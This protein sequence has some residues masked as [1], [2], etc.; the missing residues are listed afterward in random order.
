MTTVTFTG[1]TVEYGPT[2]DVISVGQTQVSLILPS[3]TSTFT[4]SIVDASDSVPVVEIDDDLLQVVIDGVLADVLEDSA[5][6]QIDLELGTVTSAAGTSTFLGLSIEFGQNTVDRYF[7]IDGVNLPNITSVAEWNAFDDSITNVGPA[8]GA[9]APGVAIPWATFNTATVTEDDEF[10]GRPGDEIFRGGIGDDYFNSSDGA[11]TYFGGTG[12]DQVNFRGDPNGV[13]ANL[14]TGKAIDGWGKTDTLNS[15]EMLR[16]SMFDDTLIGN[17]GGNGIRGLAGDDFLNGGKGIDAVRYDRDER[18]GG[19]AGVTVNLKNGT[20]T[21]GFGD[22][23][24]LRNF[25]NVMGTEVKDTLIGSGGKNTLVGLGGNDRLVGLNGRDDLQGGDGRDVL[26]GGAGNDMLTG[27]RQADRFVFKGAFG[28]DTIT[29]FT[30]AGKLEKIDLSA[31]A[32]IKGFR[33]LKKSHL[34]NVNGDAVIDD[35][36]G[37]TIT[38]DGVLKGALLANDFIF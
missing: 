31:I 22:T 26:D 5:T 11:D 24:T 6:S 17:G 18:Y 1:I 9:F 34:S 19:T 38:I 32:S 13:T 35:G 33:D 25:E 8:T 29:D 15:I 16:G 28:D 36:A 3:A 23:D 7:I 12:I 2:D 10:Y 20:A 21:D 4:Y 37:N 27:G 30:R 14:A